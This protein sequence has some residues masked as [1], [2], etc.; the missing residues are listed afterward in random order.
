MNQQG[1]ITKEQLNNFEK[2][3][4]RQDLARFMA[5]YELFKMIRQTKGSIIECGVHQGG[6]LM[7][8]AKISSNLEPYAIHRKI[9]GFDTFEGFVEI[10]K[11]D[12]SAFEN[13]SLVKGGFSCEYDVFS[14]LEGLIKEY[15]NNRFLNQFSKVELVK[16]DA[17][18]TI[19]DY[20]N[21]NQHLIVALLFLDFDLYEPTKTALEHFSSRIP[22]G[23]ILAFDEINNQFWP[24]ETVALLERYNDLNQLEI[25]KFDFDPNIAYIQF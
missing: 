11:E 9:I 25:K 5:R 16:G 4:R 24:G 3:V 21:K 13:I 18:N 19:P 14:E 22:K 15:D 20:I 6:G 8:W 12:E 23:G 10:N 7:G 1:S 17:V 2:Y